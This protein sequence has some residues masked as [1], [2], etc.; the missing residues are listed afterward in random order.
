VPARCTGKISVGSATGLLQQKRL[1]LE[2]CMA[3]MLV[4]KYKHNIPNGS[5]M[6]IFTNGTKEKR[7]H[8]Q[9]IQAFCLDLHPFS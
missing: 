6:V 8:L 2:D 5:L 4:K 1:N 3:T 7:K 9:Q